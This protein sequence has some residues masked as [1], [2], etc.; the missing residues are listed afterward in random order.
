[1]SNTDWIKIFR[2]FSIIFTSFQRTGLSSEGILF[3]DFGIIVIICI[4]VIIIFYTY[5]IRTDISIVLIVQF[6]L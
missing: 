3:L 6:L 5:L 4:V 1:M 2:F